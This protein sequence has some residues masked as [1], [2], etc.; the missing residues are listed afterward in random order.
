MNDLQKLLK[1]DSG[2][3][4]IKG[5]FVGFLYDLIR[6][7]VPLGDV[8]KLLEGQLI[9]EPDE[10]IVYTNGWLAN[11]AAWIAE[12]LTAK[13]DSANESDQTKIT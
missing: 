6:D 12:K 7:Y 4:K 9:Y 8:T 13:E 1:N 11:Y 2:N 10:E 3:V 5:R